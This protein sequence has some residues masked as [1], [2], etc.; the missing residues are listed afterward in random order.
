MPAVAQPIETAPKDG[1]RIIGKDRFGWR[2]M[3]WKVDQYEGEFWMDELD[4]EPNPTHWIEM[5]VV[6]FANEYVPNPE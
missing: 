5:P 3:W 1:T 4:S 6:L 2:E